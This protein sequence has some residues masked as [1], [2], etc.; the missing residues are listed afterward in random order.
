ML[1]KSLSH[2]IGGFSYPSISNAD[3]TNH[4]TNGIRLEKPD[5]CS[6]LSNVSIAS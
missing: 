5:N 6:D 3:L 2:F 4:L 1:P